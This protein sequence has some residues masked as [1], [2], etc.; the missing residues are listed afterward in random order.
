MMFSEA[1]PLS[2]MRNPTLSYRMGGISVNADGTLF[3]SVSTEEHCVYVTRV[4][5]TGQFR[6]FGTKDFEYPRCVCFVH[7]N[8][9][10]TL[11][12][13][14]TGNHRIVEVNG[15]GALLRSIPIPEGNRPYGIAER[16]G[17]VV[18]SLC[19]AHKVIVL[20]YTSGAV[21][22]GITIGS[23]VRGDAL[24]QLD[25]P[26]GVAFTTDGDHILVADWGNYRVSKFSVGSGEFVSHVI[27]EGMGI[28]RPSDVLQCEDGSIFATHSDGVAHVGVD[29][30]SGKNHL[31]KFGRDAASVCGLPMHAGRHGPTSLSYS[32]IHTL[33]GAFVKFF[34]GR[35]FRIQDAWYSSSRCDWLTALCV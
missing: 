1:T 27:G 25:C 5:G 19:D 4:D 15:A 12:V 16:N 2:F 35:V 18:V 20:E 13:S 32:Q 9:V 11:L 34:D 23:G 8:G 24:G 21:K 6:V 14:D 29:G 30:I 3:A 17:L 7:R 10:D 22:V 31:Y 26:C 33:N 28:V